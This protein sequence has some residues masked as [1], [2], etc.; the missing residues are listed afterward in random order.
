MFNI[1]KF[2]SGEL[3]TIYANGKFNYCYR[4]KDIRNSIEM[5]L[6]DYLESIKND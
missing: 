3:K 6:G 5:Q 1:R 4:L 2:N